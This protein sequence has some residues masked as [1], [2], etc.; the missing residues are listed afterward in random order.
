[1]LVKNAERLIDSLDIDQTLRALCRRTLNPSSHNIHGRGMIFI[2][3]TEDEGEI[4][5]SYI[6]S[7]T[8]FEHGVWVDKGARRGGTVSKQNAV[9]LLAYYG[10]YQTVK[11]Y[12]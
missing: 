8:H 11:V 12:P 5:Y 2:T 3:K 1:M 9:E 10:D 6:I 7:D 4:M